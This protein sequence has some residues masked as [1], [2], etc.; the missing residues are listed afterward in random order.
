MFRRSSSV[1][2]R[3]VSAFLKEPGQAKTFQETLAVCEAE[4]RD[5][6]SMLSS[7]F[8]LLQSKLFK[9][10][11]ARLGEETRYVMKHPLGCLPSADMVLVHFVALPLVFFAA[12]CIGRGSSRPL[13]Q[14]PAAKMEVAA[15]A[16]ATADA[17]AVAPEEQT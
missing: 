10:R 13:V 11:I 7:D 1:M 16:A 15:A 4:S 5:L 17:A 8:L 3:A 12:V 2:R 6:A 9:Y 14:P